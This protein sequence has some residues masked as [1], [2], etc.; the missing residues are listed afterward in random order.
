M[1]L[2]YLLKRLKVFRQDYFGDRLTRFT[3]SLSWLGHFTLDNFKF[4]YLGEINQIRYLRHT[5]RQKERYISGIRGNNG[6]NDTVPDEIYPAW[7]RYTRAVI[8]ITLLPA[9]FLIYWIRRYYRIIRQQSYDFFLAV[10]ANDD[11]TNQTKEYRG[12]LGPLVLVPDGRR[13]YPRGLVLLAYRLEITEGTPEPSLLIDCGDGFS[14]EYA[15]PLPYNQDNGDI[16]LIIELPPHAE[17]LA[18]Q[19]ISGTG[20]YK[21]EQVKMR[22]ISVFTANRL[23]REQYGFDTNAVLHALFIR[24]MPGVSRTHTSRSSY[25]EWYQRYHL[26][27]PYD[28]KAITRHIESMQDPVYFNLVLHIDNETPA[29]LDETIS[30]ILKQLYPHWRLYVYAREQPTTHITSVLNHYERYDERVSLVMDPDTAGISTRLN[31][32]YEKLEGEFTIFIEQGD[33]IPPHALY[34]SASTLSVSPHAELLYSDYDHIDQYGSQHSPVFKPDWDRH[35]IQARNYIQFMTCYRQVTLAAV[36]DPD[37]DLACLDTSLTHTRL[38]QRLAPGTIEH[39]P[40]ILLHHRAE[41]DLSQADLSLA[42]K[43]TLEGFREIS[44]N[45]GHEIVEESA[46]VRIRQTVPQPPPLISLVVLTRDRVS[47]LSHCIHGLLDKT[48]YRNIEVIIVDNGSVEEATLDFLEAITSKDE[49]VSVLTRPT[50]FNFSALNNDAVE[51]ARGEYI[52]LINND[53]AVIEPG[54]LDE[55]L[56]VLIED[57]VGIVG[58]KLLYENDT[59]QHAGVIVGIGGVAG[60][61]FRHLPRYSRGYDDRLLYT[62]ELSC[63]TAA[64]LLTKKSIYQSV[65]GLNAENLR[66]AFNDV[67]YCLKVREQGYKVVWTPHAELYHLESA[68]RGS[69]MA[70]ENIDRWNAEYN[71]MR[72]KWR[73]VLRYDPYYN[74]NLTITDEDFSYAHP[75]RLQHPWERHRF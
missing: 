4:L 34:L 3:S 57:D 47:L 53:I 69:D 64:C 41:K 52:G 27:R 56:G 8:H 24:K 23:L 16:A 13:T 61:G 49:R 44:R 30:S 18:F 26:L 12:D 60:H 65:G 20:L 43:H 74:P 72:D 38:A 51:H 14:G 35:L 50:E 29:F 39:I 2:K 9:T 19:A 68:S 67:D 5:I 17:S 63:V 46:G 58:A 10:P 70:R 54:W 59:I 48:S 55:M 25:P 22:E 36:T 75:P 37:P 6:P 7:L 31:L 45:S 71:Y 21:L 73:N 15:I 11:T 28:H 40:Y 66:V 32:V 33:L 1:A 42:R 62:H